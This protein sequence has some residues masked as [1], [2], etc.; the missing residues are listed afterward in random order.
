MKRILFSAAIIAA[1]AITATAQEVARVSDISVVP[2][3]L[4]STGKPAPV[5]IDTQKQEVTIFDTEFNVVKK[6][7]ILLE[8]LQAAVILKLLQ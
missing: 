5:G 4:T 3:V 2:S 6:S 8:L 1:S 7:T